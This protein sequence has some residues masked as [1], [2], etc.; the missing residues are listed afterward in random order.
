MTASDDR[1]ARI[2]DAAS[3]ALLATL[4]GHEREVHTAAFSP[5]GQRIVSASD[6]KTARVWNATN[7]E[8]LAK[9][10]GHTDRVWSAAFSPDGKRVVTA[11]SDNTA[12]LWDGKT[13]A[14][15][16]TLA[17]HQSTVGSAAF[18]PD[19]QRVVTALQSVQGI[20]N[21]GLFHIVGQPNLEI[22]TNRKACARYGVNVS[23]VESA[24][25]VA[26]GG[27]AFSQMVEG[28]KLYDI[29]LRLPVSL[30]NDPTVIAQ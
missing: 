27:K 11:S 29:V 24:V 16:A 9:L 19:G 25:Q 14:A 6:D 7:G 1:T 13:G 30:R 21:V 26:I 23:D 20:E 18:S 10:E 28:E 15:L 2:W 3:G 17:G 4:Q 22:K 5:D 12:R 8:M